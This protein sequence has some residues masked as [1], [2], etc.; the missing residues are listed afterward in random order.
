ML[1][2]FF[3]DPRHSF[4]IA[5]PDSFVTVLVLLAVAVAVAALVDRAASRAREARRA[6]QEAELLALFAGAV[7][8]GADL[9]ALLERVRETYGQR[10]VSL[11]ARARRRGRARSASDAPTDAD[12]DTAIDAGDGEYRLLLAGPRAART[13]PAGAERRRESGRRAWCGSANS[14][15]RPSRRR[16]SPR[17]TGCGAR[18]CPR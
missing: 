11:T 13:G 7:L 14:P 8:R 2:Y 15:T 9:P 17:P 5:E 16:R 1:N 3:V 10:A 12:A 6:S 18:C 4:T